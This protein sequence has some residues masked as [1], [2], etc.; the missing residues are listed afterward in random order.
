MRDSALSANM[1]GAKIFL[2]EDASAEN[3]GKL[4]EM[5]PNESENNH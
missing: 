4:S 1:P 2:Y 3:N 5:M